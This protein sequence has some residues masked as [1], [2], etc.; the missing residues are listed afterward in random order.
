MDA[1]QKVA[2][3]LRRPQPAGRLNIQVFENERCLNKSNQLLGQFDL[4]GISARAL[5]RAP[6][7]RSPLT[8]W[9]PLAF[10]EHGCERQEGTRL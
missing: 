3:H 7:L 1:H 6:D 10:F 4:T 9:M 2:N 5:L 8:T